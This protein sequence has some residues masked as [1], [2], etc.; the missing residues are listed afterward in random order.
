M[1]DDDFADVS[2]A[3]SSSSSRK[4]GGGHVTLAALAATLAA[5][6]AYLYY[7]LYQVNGP[8]VRLRG[9]WARAIGPVRACVC[10]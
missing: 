1:A 5:A 3:S 9:R 6:S 4:L 7:T 10:G 2:G 8:Q